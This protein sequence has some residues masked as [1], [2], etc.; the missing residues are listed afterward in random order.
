M[1]K[2]QSLLHENKNHVRENK[3]LMKNLSWHH[4]IRSKVSRHFSAIKAI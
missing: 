4:Q 1:A 2:N 3:I